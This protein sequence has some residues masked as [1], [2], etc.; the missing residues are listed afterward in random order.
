MSAPLAISSAEV[1]LSINDKSDQDAPPVDHI[2][3]SSD[4]T[5]RRCCCASC[6]FGEIFGCDDNSLDEKPNIDP[7][8]LILRA[9]RE[10]LATALATSAMVSHPQDQP[11]CMCC[12]ELR[13]AET[14]PAL[15]CLMRSRSCRSSHKWWV[16]MTVAQAIVILTSAVVSSVQIS[17]EYLCQGSHKNAGLQRFDCPDVARILHEANVTSLDDFEG[18]MRIL[19]WGPQNTAPEPR[20]RW[21]ARNT[22]GFLTWRAA[23]RSRYVPPNS[24]FPLILAVAI[25]GAS[26]IVMGTWV[27]DHDEVMYPPLLYRF[28]KG[29]GLA[30]RRPRYTMARLYFAITPVVFLLNVGAVLSSMQEFFTGRIPPLQDFVTFFFTLLHLDMISIPTVALMLGTVMQ[31]RNCTLLS[32]DLAQCKT[33]QDYLRW[34]EWYKTVVG[35][36]HIWSWRVSPLVTVS[37]FFFALYSLSM[38]AQAVLVYID[39]VQMRE[40]ETWLVAS[41]TLPLGQ[42][43][44]ALVWLLI[45]LFGLA[46]IGGRYR[47]LGVLLATL[48][49]EGVIRDTEPDKLLPA[50]PVVGK[51]RMENEDQ[52]DQHHEE[53][54]QREEIKG[55]E[56]NGEEANGEEEHSHRLVSADSC[57][58]VETKVTPARKKERVGMDE[59]EVV[60]HWTDIDILQRRAAS[61]TLFDVPLDYAVAMSALR[62][63]FYTLLGTVVGIAAVPAA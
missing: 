15:I 3:G 33:H 27:N 31:V 21:Y 32:Q 50:E 7:D 43:A 60:Q 36:L 4:S 25:T 46:L 23:T 29:E 30:M 61:F 48:Q 42:F 26:T 28:K 45:L 1:E 52:Q 51:E 44:N 38:L 5:V 12:D 57:A 39:I 14:L 9:E 20:F 62:F 41:V 17:D 63:L 49:L 53:G 18:Q 35:A 40:E 6:G 16:I 55:E 54:K 24:C 58:E 19:G 8:N 2:D 56:A 22:P 59:S 13:C 34:R 10:R 47:R 11:K 37:A